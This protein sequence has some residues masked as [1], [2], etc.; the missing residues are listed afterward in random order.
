MEVI[1]AWQ[2]SPAVAPSSP[3][4]APV[5]PSSSIESRLTREAVAELSGRLLSVQRS[6]ETFERESLDEMDALKESLPA[7]ATDDERAFNVKKLRFNF[8]RTVRPRLE[9]LRTRVKAEKTELGKRGHLHRAERVLA[10]C[11]REFGG[12]KNAWRGEVVK[13]REKEKSEELRGDRIERL[14]E[15]VKEGTAALGRIEMWMDDAQKAWLEYEPNFQRRMN[16]V[17]YLLARGGQMEGNIVAGLNDATVSADSAKVEEETR[18]SGSIVDASMMDAINA[19]VDGEGPT[20]TISGMASTTGLD[21]KMEELT[22]LALKGQMA[23]I[24]NPDTTISAYE[25]TADA[26]NAIVENS[27][28]VD[29]RSADADAGGADFRAMDYEIVDEKI[30]EAEERMRKMFIDEFPDFNDLVNDRVSESEERLTA[31]LE[32]KL[33]VAA[34]KA[35]VGSTKVNP[36][37]QKLLTLQIVQSEDRLKK[38]ILDSNESA[39][40]AAAKRMDAQDATLADLEAKYK[41]VVEN[42]RTITTVIERELLKLQ[43]K[44]RE[45][46]GFLQGRLAAAGASLGKAEAESVVVEEKEAEANLVDKERPT[47]FSRLRSMFWS[48]PAAESRSEPKPVPEPEAPAEFE[49]DADRLTPA[50]L[51]KAAALG[52]T[53]IAASP[54]LSSDAKIVLI[55]DAEKANAFIKIVTLLNNVPGKASIKIVGL[56]T[57]FG[58]SPTPALLQIAFSQTLVVIFQLHTMC[59]LKNGSFLAKNFPS[60]VKKFLESN[61]IYKCGVGIAGD[62]FKLK[63]AYGIEMKQPLDLSDLASACGVTTGLKLVDLYGNY[64]E[65]DTDFKKKLDGKSFDWEAVNLKPE[66][67]NYAANDALAALKVYYN[68]FRWPEEVAPGV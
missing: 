38:L 17:E 11:E 16:K 67:I 40:K 46:F 51:K 36:A 9:R 1:L 6:V 63:S 50:I 30:S 57:E 28:A 25:R 20:V 34:E 3:A 41:R 7:A 55:D 49:S 15:E 13:F 10:E 58:G 39:R 23:D 26:I 54:S 53:P 64:V 18:H 5:A 22:A 21:N 66:A 37:L 60:E 19:M 45:D 4:S 47:F 42:Q 44:A 12:V 52:I 24:G 2:T 48:S 8:A 61:G 62:S 31:L 68:M 14:A 35:S 32:E 27:T 59:H 65:R 56:D 33:A 29:S 43:T